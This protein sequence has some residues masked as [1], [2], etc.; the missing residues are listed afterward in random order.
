MADRAR[1]R[2]LAG[3]RFLSL[4]LIGILA[5]I[6]SL[7]L[8]CGTPPPPGDTLR[9]GIEGNPTNLDPRF[10]TD[11]YSVRI[12]GLVYEGLF[13]DEIDGG[14]APALAEG[15]EVPDER[16]YRITLKPGL[17]WQD[18]SPIVAADVAATYR[19]L[20]DPKNASPAQDTFGRLVAI[21]T[22]DDRTVVLR[23]A[24]PF[25]P[26]LDKLT[27]PIVPARLQDPAKLAAAPVGSGPYRLVDFQLGQKVILEANPRYR[28][29]P[30]PI[31]RL[32][33][34][35]VANDT[36]RLLQLN[37]GDLDLVVNA[38][39]NFAVKFFAE[40]PGRLVQREPGINYSYLGFNLADRHG[41]VSRRE[42]RQAIAHAINREEIIAALLFGMARPA[43]SL[44]APGNWAYD[45][46]A[47]TY[48]YD[49]ERAKQLLDAAGFPD[50][51]G[52]GPAVRFTLSYKTST[53]KLRMRIAEVIAG[54]LARVG[55]GFER[56]SLEWGTFFQDI[57]SG[58]FQTYTLTWVGVNDPDHLYYVYHS[59]MQPPRG[60]NRGFYADPQVDQW[61]DASRR[62]ND[63][64]ERR[65]L[66]GLVQQKVAADC[67]YVDLWWADNVAVQTDRLQ[68][69]FLRPSGDYRALAT[70]RLRP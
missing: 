5:A 55:I 35:V 50:P 12:L 53:N 60:G 51:D 27:R 4:A 29:G 38:V 65:R 34:R 6:F 59:S 16:T 48:P 66:Y 67:V 7:L 40:M 1:S 58:N 54:Q 21:E 52:D 23:L 19:F 26:F 20:A 33:F 43:T 69:F 11:A 22:P 25:S 17:V 37:K 3:P 32:E 47:P 57:K 2:R 49:P 41:I 62:T 18:G 46:G 44:L 13:A 64:A 30:P 10:A 36:T 15:Y 9:I 24:E 56:R 68:G 42:V 39:P 63:R 14:I 8:A 70:A 61:L 28:Q 31:P 45:P